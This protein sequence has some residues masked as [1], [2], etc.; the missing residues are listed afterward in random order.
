MQ[1]RKT[2]PKGTAAFVAAALAL[3]GEVV[4]RRGGNDLAADFLGCDRGTYGRSPA[5]AALIA[6]ASEARAQVLALAVVLA[7][8]EDATHTGSWRKVDPA[9]ARYLQFLTTCGYGLADVERRACGQDPLP[10]TDTTTDAD[11]DD[12]TAV[13]DAGEEDPTG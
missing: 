4:T 7:G 2:A 8:Y 6:Q 12:S 1:R 9:T 10:L 5:L 11:A 3:D 13:A